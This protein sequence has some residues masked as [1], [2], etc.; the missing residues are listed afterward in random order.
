[1]TR[2]AE[3]WKLFSVLTLVLTLLAAIPH[4]RI[5]ASQNTP[6]IWDQSVASGFSKGTGSKNDPYVIASASELAY[7]SSSVLSGE[8]YFG[9]YI[10]LEC[11]VIINDETFEF[12]P[13]SGL[14]KVSDNENTTFFGS[15]IKG[16]QSA[17]S[18]VFDAEASVRGSQYK[19]AASSSPAPGTYKGRINQLKPIGSMS[20]PFC[21][22]FDG[23]GHTVSGLFANTRLDNQ[24]LFGYVKDATI[25]GVHVE[26]SYI[27]GGA[28]CASVVGK[29][30]RSEI[31]YCSAQ[32]YVFGDGGC[33]GIVGGLEESSISR[34]RSVC[35]I[36]A[37]NNVGG[38]AGY[39]TGNISDCYSRSGLFAINACAGIVSYAGDG[40]VERCYFAGSTFNPSSMSPI[41]GAGNASVR[42]CY[43]LQSSMP[44]YTGGFTEEQMRSSKS[45]AGFDF[46]SVWTMNSAQ[47]CGYP[48]L[49]NLDKAPHEHEFDNACD[50]S[51]NSCEYIREAAHKYTDS[52][53][54]D[55]NDHF[56][57]CVICKHT[58]E[59]SPHVWASP[60]DTDCDVCGKTR[61]I[62][63]DYADTPIGDKNGHRYECTLC[64]IQT[65][66]EKHVSSGKATEEAAEICTVCKYVISPKK[67]H[68]HSFSG[69]YTPV[70]NG[71]AK[72]CP[73][74]E[75]S[76][77]EDH[78][79]S[80]GENIKDP[81]EKDDGIL[82]RLCELCGARSEEVI[83]RLPISGTTNDIPVD[84]PQESIPDDDQDGD[85]KNDK[86]AE[87][88]L[89]DTETEKNGD[90][91]EK[92]DNDSSQSLSLVISISAITVSVISLIA[93]TVIAI[94]VIK[95]KR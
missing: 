62:S 77:T 38:I 19:S 23:K 41:C 46:S 14:I 45:F 13:D 65:E 81:T 33:A 80:S 66:N 51:C 12:D 86:D 83:P 10:V 93:N 85:P 4:A 82:L 25:T 17:D 67:D 61:N 37:V 72:A 43:F 53:G 52:Y 31:S 39:S 34:S 6:Q 69:E 15:G 50:T 56:K 20:S 54:Y 68:V 60:C 73:C 57:T 59:K 11:D 35:V 8:T 90:T 49:L 7:L 30:L 95:K 94:T 27:S 44:T 70:S 47:S 22:N 21:G 79:W 91:E 1:M 36:G 64:H 48:G 9:K 16:D 32:A 88:S 92:K 5:K 29:A 55:T 89:T 18:S 71:H 24:G 40:S 78:I 42:L 3:I 28:Y 84:I 74:G 87:T 26:N 75:Y 76:K 2:R 63:H 58:D